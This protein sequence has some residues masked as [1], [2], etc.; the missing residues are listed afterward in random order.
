MTPLTKTL[1]PP[2][3]L[4]S[5]PQSSLA[6]AIASSQ[7]ITVGEQA[8]TMIAKHL[9]HMM[10]QKQGV[11]ADTDPEYLHQMRVGSRRLRAAL[12]LFGDN[13]Q[14]PKACQEKHVRH[15]ARTLGEIRN[16]DVIIQRLRNDYGPT[17]PTAEFKHLDRAVGAL[18]QQRQVIFRE[19]KRQLKQS[20]LKQAYTRWLKQPKYAPGAEL[21]LQVV[22]P[23]LLSPAIAQLL[24][25]PGWWISADEAQ[26]ERRQQLHDLRKACKQ[27]RYQLEGFRDWY[28]ASFTVWIDE[29][30]DL[31]ECLGNVQDMTVLRQ[32]VGTVLPAGQT[33][34]ALE[35]QLQ[36]TE[37][38]ALRHWETLRPNYLNPERRYQIHQ[39]ILQPAVE[40]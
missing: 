35:A 21:P 28:D 34:P 14:L 12:H 10:K 15:L 5:A 18:G 1:E 39:L 32:V 16:L 40:A 17:L 38:A 6:A 37:Q 19:V 33:L 27:A 20:T 29:L 13:L 24:R 36:Q 11:L 9:Q 23:D 3:P 8:H 26:P 7:L 25:H 4:D 22:L 30:K 2:L 31:Q